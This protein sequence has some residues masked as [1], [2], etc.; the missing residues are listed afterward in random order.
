MPTAG[1]SAVVGNLTAV[2]PTGD[3]YLIQ[4][5]NGMARPIGSDVNF[6]AGEVV[7]NMIV[8]GIDS[9]GR[10]AIYN[11]KVPVTNFVE[12]ISG[13]FTVAISCAGHVTRAH[14]NVTAC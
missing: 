5:A 1:T 3:G 7:A 14:P 2:D 4:L 9:S 6:T 11:S 10:S 12:D 13:Y 8:S